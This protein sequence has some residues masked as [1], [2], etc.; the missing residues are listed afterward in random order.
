MLEYAW[1]LVSDRKRRLLGCAFCRSVWQQL[2]QPQRRAVRAAEKY[3]DDLVNANGLYPATVRMRSGC[4]L[5]AARHPSDG[6]A[7]W[8]PQLRISAAGCAR[9]AGGAPDPEQQAE[10]RR[11]QAGYVRDLFGNPARHPRLAQSWLSSTVS[12]LALG[13]Y[14]TREFDR[15]PILADALM[16]TGC[17]DD[18]VL[19]H[20][21]Q[22]TG[23]ARGCWVVDLVLGMS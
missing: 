15:L 17:D 5:A 8:L 23:H 21:R 16:D 19:T 2:S 10:E 12:A 11:R 7:D 9:F 6:Y 20:C 18:A 13:I 3:A 22:Q 14:R 1:V 4:T